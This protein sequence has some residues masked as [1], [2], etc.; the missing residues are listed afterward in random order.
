MS[1]E[2]YCLDALDVH[3]DEPAGDTR[4]W[5]REQA[6]PRPPR[7]HRRREIGTGSLR[8]QRLAHLNL[9]NPTILGV[10]PAV[11]GHRS[12]LRLRTGCASCHQPRRPPRFSRRALAPLTGLFMV[13]LTTRRGGAPV[14]AEST[15]RTATPRSTKGGRGREPDAMSKQIAAAQCATKAPPPPTR[16]SSLT[17]SGVMDAAL[18][19]PRP[20]ANIGGIPAAARIGPR[21]STTWTVFHGY[22]SFCHRGQHEEPVL[23]QPCAAVQFCPTAPEH[24]RARRRRA[25]R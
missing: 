13:L 24:Q 10:L 7:L 15:R 2:R 3:R 22:Q 16:P 17:P 19:T 6:T 9:W 23:A 8:Q 18:C 20:I 5:P 4:T 11:V 14:T 1:Y 25:T 21:R 12:L